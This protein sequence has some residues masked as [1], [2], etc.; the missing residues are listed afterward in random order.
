MLH[1]SLLSHSPVALLGTEFMRDFYYSFLPAR[2]LIFGAVAYVDDEPAGF[3]VA[4]DDASGFMGR[5]I[6]SG[7]WRLG[8]VMLRAVARHPIE[9]LG[10]I[11]EAIGIMRGLPASTQPRDY[12]ELLS[13]GVLPKYRERAF[14]ARRRLAISRDLATAALAEMRQ[15]GVRVCRAIVDAD[16]LE[17]RLFY[18]G[19]GWRPGSDRVPGWRKHT[20]EFLMD[21]ATPAAAGE[22]VGA[23]E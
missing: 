1:A 22:T 7:W 21:L 20:V 16:N 11:R 17:A 6:R 3:I 15:R 8:G 2:G 18:V 14:V 10:A 12:G 4:T 5:G 13:F 19:S 9:R 23:T